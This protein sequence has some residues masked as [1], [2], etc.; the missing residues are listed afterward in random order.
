ME[1]LAENLHRLPEIKA[2]ISQ[3]NDKQYSYTAIRNRPITEQT[4]SIVMTSSNRSKQVYQTF[5]TLLHSS[6]K[7]VQIILVD[8]STTDAVDAEILKK[9]PFWID[10][11]QI[12]RQNKFWINPCVN[13]NIGF[14]FVKGSKVILQN[15]EVCHIGDVVSYVNTN[16]NDNNYLV[17]D[18]KACSNFA[19]NDFLY[20]IHEPLTT[21]IQNAPFY[22]CWQQ[23][24]KEKDRKLH[25]M[26]AFSKSTLEKIKGFSL[27]YSFSADFDDDDLLLIVKAAGINFQSIS[28]EDSNVGGIHL[29]HVNS[30]IAWTA[31]TSNDTL[32]QKKR[33]YCSKFSNQ[34]LEIASGSNLIEMI[35]RFDSLNRLTQP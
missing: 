1:R 26:A 7:D 28:H 23:N 32:F 3:Q 29:Y 4:I 6:Y 31:R 35:H 12:N 16:V 10:F 21:D 5:F 30:H 22:S 33:D 13:Q 14:Q 18:V 2:L 20:E 27:D 17:F 9:F 24:A 34:Y 15:S 8:D 19:S 11:I 25:F